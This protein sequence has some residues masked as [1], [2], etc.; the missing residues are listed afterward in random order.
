MLVLQCLFVYHG[1]DD[2]RDDTRWR[3]VHYSMKPSKPYRGFPLTANGNGQWSKK[4]RGKVHYFGVWADWQAALNRYLE[5]RDYLHTG[6]V[7]PTKAAN[8]ASLLN[9]FLEE[10]HQR[11]QSGGISRQT[12]GEYQRACDMIA[13][14]GASRPLES[15]TP[16]D[17][18]R[19][20]TILGQG[21]RP[22]THKKRLQVARMVF[23][24]AG[25]HGFALRYKRHLRAP[26]RAKM[27]EHERARGEQFYTAEQ[28]RKLVDGAVDNLRA[29]ILMGINCG[30]GPQDC[31][32]LPASAVDLETGWHDYWR[33]K[34]QVDRRCPLWPETVTA[35]TAVLGSP[36]VFD[37]PSA[38]SVSRRFRTHAERCNVPNYGFYSLKRTLETV[39]T[40][41]DVNQ[42][43]IDHAI[44]HARHDRASVYRQRI[45]DQ[46]LLKFSDH[47]R[48]W[49]LGRITPE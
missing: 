40:S 27:R 3:N 25:E 9:I 38:N 5:Q 18:S 22:A 46:Q 23:V 44:G 14:L 45:F 41:A 7:P 39:A 12:Y 35:I 1:L 20:R 49:Y 8:L 24:L 47:V 30:F 19:L 33:T 21:A 43:V 26:S 42:A 10:K 34:T 32:T 31:F 4:I 48:D 37:L 15:L 17:F 6:Q 28:V 2:T 16:Q 36:L 11:R 29:M 13:T